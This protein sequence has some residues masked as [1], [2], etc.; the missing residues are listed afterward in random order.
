MRADDPRYGGGAKNAAAGLLAAV[1]YSLPGQ[2][3]GHVFSRPRR[4]YWSYGN[5]AK[6][7]RAL[8]LAVWAIEPTAK[9]RALMNV[10][11]Q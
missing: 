5:R 7:D 4:K 10:S 6:S 1:S 9:P 3:F 2:D 11:V 8:H